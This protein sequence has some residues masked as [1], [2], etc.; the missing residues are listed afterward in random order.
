MR[1]P[2]VILNRVM[3]VQVITSSPPNVPGNAAWNSAGNNAGNVTV[4][5]TVSQ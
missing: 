2:R 1:E 3:Y 5:G 4:G